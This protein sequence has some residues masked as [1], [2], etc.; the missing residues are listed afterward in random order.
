[1]NRQYKV[2]YWNGRGQREQYFE[3]LKEATKF[4][5]TCGDDQASLWQ[6]ITKEV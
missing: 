3:T 4:L 6:D 1:M 5:E 2:S